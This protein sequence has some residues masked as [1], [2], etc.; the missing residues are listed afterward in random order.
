ME[1]K[2]LIFR[3]WKEDESTILYNIASD[4][5]V[6]LPCG[7]HPFESVDF[8]KGV[9][10]NWSK[11]GKENFCII[12]KNSNNIIGDI[13]LMTNKNSLAK[14]GDGD[15]EISYFLGCEYWGKGYASEALKEMIR[16]SFEEKDIKRLFCGYFIENVASKRVQEKCGFKFYKE[17]E[18]EYIPHLEIEKHVVRMILFKEDWQMEVIKCS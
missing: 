5:R 2:R 6:A 8:A 9:I 12:E 13:Q 15:G 3:R 16:Y 17:I 10:Q 11:E 7:F 1:T 4:S 14:I 18:N